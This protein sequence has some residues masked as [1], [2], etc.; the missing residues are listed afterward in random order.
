MDKR[1]AG[2]NKCILWIYVLLTL[3]HTTFMRSTS[4]AKPYELIPFWNYQDIQDH[5]RVLLEICMNIIMFVPIGVL[6]PL[7]YS[8]IKWYQLLLSSCLFS[9]LIELLQLVFERGLCETDDVIHNTLGAMIGY[10]LYRFYVKK[11]NN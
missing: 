9:V 3:A 11:K 10:S 1:L 6:I 2:L 7:L 8:H 5:P 4:F